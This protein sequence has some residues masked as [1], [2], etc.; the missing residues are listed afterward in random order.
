M[1]EKNFSTSYAVRKL[2]NSDVSIVLDLCRGNSAY[3]KLCPPE[4]CAETVML[5]MTAL[6][7]GKTDSDKYFVGYFSGEELV[8]VLDSIADYPTRGTAFVGLL[9]VD[10]SKQKRGVGSKIVDE[11]FSYL[12]TAGVNAIRLAWVSGNV[13]AQ[14]FWQKHG[15][16][17]VGQT[18]D[19]EG[20]SVVVAERK[21]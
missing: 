9:M 10:A 8:A 2:H 14:K 18:A 11:L 13:S 17:E 12:K 16:A 1:N 19:T 3:Y 6:P 4:A 20:R 21:L 5:D 15:F 7:P